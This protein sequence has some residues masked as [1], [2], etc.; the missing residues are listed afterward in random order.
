MQSVKLPKITLNAAVMMGLVTVLSI[1]L[2]T[3]NVNALDKKTQLK[4][5]EMEYLS[6]CASCHGRDAKGN[7]PVASVLTTKPSDL[8]TITKR[9]SGKFPEEHI[10]KVID[11]R[12]MIK[13]HGNSLMPIWGHRF[14]MMEY[15]AADAIA[16]PPTD[17]DTQALVFGRILSLVGYLES[18][19]VE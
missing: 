2:S 19:Q 17:L 7:G 8:T 5:G 1:I 13:P 3:S 15:N 14:T 16:Y 11:G 4:L 10:Y 6:N 9:F 18:I 12:D